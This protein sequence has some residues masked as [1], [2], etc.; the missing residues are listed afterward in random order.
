LRSQNSKISNHFLISW[1]Q[2]VQD[3]KSF[4]RFWLQMVWDLKAF[5]DPDYKWF[6]DLKPFLKSRLQMVQDL[7]PFFKILVTNGLRSRSQ[8][9]RDR[10]PVFETNGLGSQTMVWDLDDK[11]FDISN[12]FLRFGLQMVED[13]KP[14]FW[15]LGHK[16][17]EIS[18]TNWIRGVNDATSRPMSVLETWVGSGPNGTGRGWGKSGGRRRRAG[19]VRCEASL[20]LCCLWATSPQ[21]HRLSP[22][23]RKSSWRWPA[24]SALA[25]RAASEGTPRIQFCFFF[26][27]VFTHPLQLLFS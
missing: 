25:E 9:V 27:F 16:W 5:W 22:W 12:H 7:K 14:M 18:V 10:K 23:T 2:M 11:S 17:F 15:D 3:L 26:C 20:L 24:L 4:L 21:R 19:L 8:M 13:L 6:G 1:L